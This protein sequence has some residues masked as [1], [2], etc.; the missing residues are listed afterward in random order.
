MKS[1]FKLIVLA[2]AVVVTILAAVFK[3]DAPAFL[4][5]L[6]LTNEKLGGITSTIDLDAVEPA[7]SV[8]LDDAAPIAPAPDGAE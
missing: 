6:I 4:D 8:D 7:P 5:S 2:V 1:Y 3:F